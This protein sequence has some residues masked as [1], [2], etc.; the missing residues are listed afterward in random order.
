MLG[1]S[2]PSRRRK[3]SPRYRKPHADFP[4]TPHP[5]G[6]WCKKVKGKLYYFGKIEGDENGQAALTLWLEQ[7]DAILLTGKKPYSKG[8]R[9][10]TLELCDLFMARK[11]HLLANGE[12]VKATFDDYHRSCARILAVFGKAYPVTDLVAEDFARLREDMARN[13]GLVRLGNEIQRVR[14]VFK[15]GYEEGLIDRPIRYG[16]GFNKPN[17]RAM[18]E[19]ANR[20]AARM[21]EAEEIRQLLDA[22]DVHM[23]AMILLGANCGFGNHDVGTLPLGAV[24]LDGGWIDYPRPKTAVRRRCPL[25]PETVT[26]LRAS[27]AKRKEPTHEEHSGLFFVTKYGGSWAKDVRRGPLTT[28]M[29]RLL[30]DLGLHAKGRGFYAL[31]HVVETVGGES[32]DQ[33][34]LDLIMGHVDD[35]MAATYR[36]RISDD[37]LQAVVDHVRSWLF[38]AAAT[39]ATTGTT[40]SDPDDDRPQLRV[41][42]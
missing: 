31:R 29:R 7:K 30:D 4:L 12:I 34:A 11:D 26:A 15:F 27:L 16:Q 9:L 32:R 24:D 6:R 19:A 2:S 28:R 42:G 3:K 13:Y 41:V 33:P 40:V 8:D 1:N 5:S 22:A 10:T 23:K 38:D 37:R 36:E 20:Q 17:R 35:S 14:S 18:R 21:F 39:A 25:W